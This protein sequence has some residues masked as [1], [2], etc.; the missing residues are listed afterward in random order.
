MKVI[1]HF[2]EKGLLT[3]KARERATGGLAEPDA[4]GYVGGKNVTKSTIRT[5]FVT[6]V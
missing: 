6:A 5:Q 2:I 4:F 1:R 3:E